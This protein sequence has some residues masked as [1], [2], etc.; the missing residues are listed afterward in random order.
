MAA[1]AEGSG[2]SEKQRRRGITHNTASS[3]GQ[4]SFT[5]LQGLPSESE[6][7]SQNSLCEHSRL[8][9]QTPASGV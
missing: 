2:S 9:R 5:H 4:R 8:T 7:V 1:A 3:P 6:S